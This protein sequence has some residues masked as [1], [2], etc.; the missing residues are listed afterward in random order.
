MSRDQPAS[1]A[2]RYKISSPQPFV[3]LQ[4]ETNTYQPVNLTSPNGTP[5]GSPA[6]PARSRM[7]DQLPVQQPSR[8]NLDALQTHNLRQPSNSSST[9]GYEIPPSPVSP[10]SA[11]SA[12]PA[13]GKLFTDPFAADRSQRSEL[14]VQT[15]E[16]AQR[17]AQ[18]FHGSGPASDKLRN[19]VGAFMTA[20]R[21]HEEPAVR[22]PGKSRARQTTKEEIWEVTDGKFGEIDTVLKKIR[23]DWPFVLESDFSPSTLALSLLSQTPTLTHPPLSSFLKLHDALSSS[24]QSAVQAHFQSFAASLPAHAT[25]LS[26]LGRA[27]QSVRSSK[28]ALREARDGFAGKGKSELAGVRARERVVRDMLNILDIM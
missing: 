21:G 15:S 4:A 26:T 25:F 16:A 14:R 13:S 17:E 28:D 27:Q 9:G 8:R 6:R 1:S 3:S 18:P 19:V 10:V 22:R 2:S 24:L 11:T 23:K 5:G 7:R 12:P 20:G